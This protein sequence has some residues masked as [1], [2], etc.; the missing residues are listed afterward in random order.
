MPDAPLGTR[1][2]PI[3]R[4]GPVEAREADLPVA[5]AA[6][7]AGAGDADP[8]GLTPIGPP[9]ISRLTIYRVAIVEQAEGRPPMHRTIRAA[10]ILATALVGPGA[11]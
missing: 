4:P 3:P 8:T 6:P 2:P 5:L 7:P 1:A 11:L 10:P 9:D